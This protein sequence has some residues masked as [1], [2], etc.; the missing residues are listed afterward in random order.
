MGYANM[1][2]N[3][4]QLTT[5]WTA[6]AGNSITVP[7]Q[8]L[9]IPLQFWWNNNPG[10]ALPLIAMQYHEVKI[11]LELNDAKNCYWSGIL[12]NP[13]AV[14]AVP[15]TTDL[16]NAAIGHTPTLASCSLFVDYVF[17][18]S[19]E[20]RRMAQSAHEY[21]ITQIQY[22]GDES[23]SQQVNKIKLSFNHPT[24]ELIWVVQ[25]TDNISDVAPFG[26]QWFNYTDAFDTSM[27][28]NFVMNANTDGGMP[29]TAAGGSTGVFLPTTFGAGANPVAQAYLQLNG[30]DRTSPRDGR[31]WNLVQPYQHH[32]NV[33]SQGINV[34]S[35]A[36]KPEEHQPS[37]TCNFSRIDSAT[38]N[39]TLTPKTVTTT[40]GG[41]RAATIK[42]FA[43]NYNVLR[44]MSGMAGLAYSN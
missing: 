25:P 23:T 9:Y 1:V 10:L 24:K 14:P 13:L 37:G 16:S 41:S 33:P 39:L 12:A 21:L 42:V 19:D 15:L 29:G 6:P 36:L 2:G 22:T 31:Y 30:H 40:G 8:I 4:P 34:Y 27:D 17:L 28:P 26:K 18:D 20:R 5:M 11:N 35:F 43:V 44:V 7:G 32:E 3:T 38:L